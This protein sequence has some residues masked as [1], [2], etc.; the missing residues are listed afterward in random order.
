MENEQKNPNNLYGLLGKDIAYSF[1]KTYFNEKFTALQRHDHRYVNFDITS[2][3]QFPAILRDHPNLKGLNVTI[4]YKEK[5]IPYLHDLSEEARNINAVNTIKLTTKGLKGYNTDYYG[6]KNSFTPLLKKQHKNALILGTGGAAKAIAYALETLN[7]HYNFV[8]RN[9]PEMLNY[10]A[11][12]DTIIQQHNIII[13]CTP[14][15]T[16]PKTE[17]LPELPYQHIT[18]EHLL[19]D[20]VYNPPETKFLVLGKAQGAT[21]CNGLAMLKL[22]A[23]K[24]WEIWNA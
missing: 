19:Y 24:A 16:F 18:P 6:F 9:T 15:G 7:I 22:Q 8:S 21:I 2:I 10:N 3:T 23:E 20:L 14:L 4:P 11:L 13:N 5:I 1:S 12:N 17:T